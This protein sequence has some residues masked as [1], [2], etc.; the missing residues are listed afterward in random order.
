M[1]PTDVSPAVRAVALV[2]ALVLGACS[3]TDTGGAAATDAATSG[4][5]APSAAPA[6]PGVA[7]AAAQPRPCR[8]PAEQVRTTVDEGGGPVPPEQELARVVAESGNPDLA[9]LVDQRIEQ[10]MSR[11]AALAEAWVQLGGERVVT[12]ARDLPGF[13]EAAYGSLERDLPFELRFGGEAPPL[14]EIVADPVVRAVGLTVVTGVPADTDALVAAAFDAAREVGLRPVSGGPD[15][16][17]GTV[18]VEVLAAPPDL[19]A[20]WDALVNDPRVCLVVAIPTVACDGDV[21]EAARRAADTAR[22]TLPNQRTAPPDDD[23]ADEVRRSY[24]GLTLEEARAKAEQEGRDV[25][26]TV[27]EG[28]PLGAEGDLLP[29]RLSLTLCRGVVV[30]TLMDL[31]GVG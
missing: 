24:L 11:S 25:R 2:V 31:E 8:P 28:V 22:P 15:P 14:G 12:A 16:A 10:G 19:A 5:P 29:G 6:S 27:E 18:R 21:V 3:G 1:R 17:D 26:V 20:R 23:H 7:T 13:V 9:F 30:D 4:R